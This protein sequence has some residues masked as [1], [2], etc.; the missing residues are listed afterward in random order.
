MG[1]DDPWRWESLKMAMLDGL[2]KGR[3]LASGILDD[4]EVGRPRNGKISGV[5]NL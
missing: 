5:G 3:F 1:R 4:G 2:G